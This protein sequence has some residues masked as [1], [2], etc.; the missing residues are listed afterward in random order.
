MQYSEDPSERIA[1]DLPTLGQT[2]AVAVIGGTVSICADDLALRL[3]RPI[4]V[5]LAK[6][7]EH[8]LGRIIGRDQLLEPTPFSTRKLPD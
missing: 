1:P 8:Y 2:W 3:I 7:E 4:M 5:H 6:Y